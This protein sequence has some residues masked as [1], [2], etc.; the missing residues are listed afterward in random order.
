MRTLGT[1]LAAILTASLHPQA[2]TPSGGLHLIYRASK[3]YRNLAP[4][5]VGTGI[6][7]R[8]AGGYIVLSGPGNG[9]EW[10]R[11]LIGADGVMRPL[12]PAPSW[13]DSALRSTPSTRSPLMLAPRSALAPAS[14]D[15]WA[16]RKALERA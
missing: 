7:T 10:I 3:A 8:T 1:A 11:N 4:A 14:V 6:D 9:R 13:L 5:L 15:P 16:Q 12:A 2:S